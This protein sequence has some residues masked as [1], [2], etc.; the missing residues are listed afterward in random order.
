MSLTNESEVEVY[1]VLGRTLTKV[2]G[3]EKYSEV[4][5]FEFSDGSRWKMYHRQDCCE[6]VSL[7][8]VDGDVEDLLN[9]PLLIAERVW[10]SEPIVDHHFDDSSTWT[11]IKFATRK[12]HVTFRWYGVSNGCYCE[13][14]DFEEADG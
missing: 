3:A 4:V 10:K 12:G 1:P 7:E 2:T 9:V 14:A 13:T 5:S 8:S 11:F 6:R